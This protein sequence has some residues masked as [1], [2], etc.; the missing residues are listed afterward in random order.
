MFPYLTSW[1]NKII[2]RPAVKK[3]LTAVGL[4]VPF[5]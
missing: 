5:A 2:T 3:G 4:D 1:Y